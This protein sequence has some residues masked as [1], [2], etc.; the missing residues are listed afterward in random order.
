MWALFQV[1]GGREATILSLLLSLHF[2]PAR[3]ACLSLEKSIHCRL[4]PSEPHEGRKKPSLGSSRLWWGDGGE[5][6][7]EEELCP[8]VSHMSFWCCQGTGQPRLAQ[9]V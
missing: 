5:W 9:H 8:Y 4:T 2:S 6:D 1:P 7:T 3:P